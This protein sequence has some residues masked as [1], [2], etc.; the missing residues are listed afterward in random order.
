MD[1]EKETAP[2]D[3]G[4]KNKKS[5][6][7]LI[8]VLAA[9]FLLLLFAYIFRHQIVNAF[10]R[11]DRETLDT[12]VPWAETK[13][14][15]DTEEPPE[16]LPMGEHDE[17]VYNLLICGH[18]RVG[19]NT[20]VN[21]LISF[22]TTKLTANI[23]QIPRDVNAILPPYSDGYVRP[24]VNGIFGFCKK[25]ETVSDSY[26]QQRMD[27]YP[28]GSDMRGIAG[29]AAYLERN[30]CVKIHYYAVMDLTQFSNIV[31]AL[32]GVEMNVPFDL[33]YDDG[34][35]DLHIHIK[36]GEQ[37]LDG[38]TAE[39]IVRYREGFGLADI[40]RGNM[41]KM[42]MACLVK[43]IQS[44]MNIFN[45]DKI[46]KV[47]NIIGDNLVTNM[48]TSDLIYFANNAMTLDLRYV[49]F[50]TLRMGGWLDEEKGTWYSCL[51]KE[52]ALKYINNYFN[53]FD[54]PVT[55]DQFDRNGYFYM[56]SVWYWGPAANLPDY[57]YTGAEMTD[58]S[59]VP[60][61]GY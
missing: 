49:T 7:V 12:A 31:D 17:E 4:K 8:S 27:K 33:D 42:F 13:D 11:P 43:T 38:K 15:A 59:F 54:E 61:V 5:K 35:Q 23:M 44:K 41:Q 60:V 57:I 36:A 28:V 50:M 47:C 37:T 1:A 48:E 2:V 51:N 25:A 56:D 30:M 18:D 16:T 19:D 10:T 14:T 26:M 24:T 21:L 52:G 29:F 53:V 9:V 39:G 45:V 40:A 20:D 22:N 55:A 58:E 6:I 46:V 32:G 34:D 3:A